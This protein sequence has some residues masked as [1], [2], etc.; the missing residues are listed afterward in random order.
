MSH[1]KTAKALAMLENEAEARAEAEAEVGDLLAKLDT[2]KEELERT[3]GLLAAMQ[4][5]RDVMAAQ[6]RKLLK[7]RKS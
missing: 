5:D 2:V 3:K 1:K 7:G 6:V 4:R